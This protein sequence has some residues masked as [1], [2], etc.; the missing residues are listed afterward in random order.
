VGR[1]I[2]AFQFLQYDRCDG[3]GRGGADD[4]AV[5]FAKILAFAKVIDLSQ[6]ALALLDFVT[7]L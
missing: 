5:G 3:E 1:G 2:Q 7:P 6:K 4:G